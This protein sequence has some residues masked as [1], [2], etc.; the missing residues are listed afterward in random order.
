MEL[1]KNQIL[2]RDTGD[3]PHIEVEADRFAAALLMPSKAIQVAIS[4]LNTKHKVTDNWAGQRI[5]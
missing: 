3:K 5:G 4:D 2:C 1:M